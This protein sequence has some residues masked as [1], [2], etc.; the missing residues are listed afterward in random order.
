M[1][2]GHGEIEKRESSRLS[3]TEA[4]ALTREC[5]FEALLRLMRKKPFEKIT[6]SELVRCAGVSRTAFYRSYSSIDQIIKERLSGFL[7][8][9]RASLCEDVYKKDMRLWY[10][11]MLSLL[12]EHAEA[13]KILLDATDASFLEMRKLGEVFKKSDLSEGA[14]YRY[15]AFNGA[16]R[17]ILTR[18]VRNGCVDSI[19][20][21]ADL[22]YGLQTHCR[23]L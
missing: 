7:G 8:L 9:L 11:D 3:N 22:C 4:N 10:F 12:K 1:D 13:L 23:I 16:I 20:M 21:I 17:A 2:T 6:V 18:W 14:E 19:E 5:L 15:T